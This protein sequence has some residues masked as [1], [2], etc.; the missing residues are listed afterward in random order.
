MGDGDTLS[1]MSGVTR[2]LWFRRDLRLHDQPALLEA[3]ADRADVLACY[4]LDPRLTSA[5]GPRRLQFL[6]DSLRELH[7][8]LDG[9][10][11]VT[12]GRPET[13]IPNLAKAIGATSV[14]ISADFSPFGTR[15]DDAVRAALGDVVLHAAGSPYLVSPGRVVKDD[16][17]PYKVFTPYYRRWLDHGWRGPAE[18]G[19]KTA[20]W[21]DPADLP[22]AGTTSTS[23]TRARR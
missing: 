9:R 1:A 13:R 5:A 10:L 16:G 3:A 7:D 6:Y 8:A 2:L 19:P 12:R 22:G 17:E 21:I 20:H 23:P 18:S 15:R 14:H 11:L 4:V